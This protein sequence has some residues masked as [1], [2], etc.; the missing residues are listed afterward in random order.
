MTRNPD[1]TGPGLQRR[2]VLAATAAATVS[3]IAGLGT[4]AAGSGGRSF[5]LE[6]GGECQEVTALSTGETA[7]AF[8]DYR[9]GS[10]HTSTGIER[11]DVSNLFLFE[12]P[13]GTSL[14]VVHD[15]RPEGEDEPDGGAASFDIAG[16][17]A[18]GWVVIDDAGDFESA[19]DTSPD[20][21]WNRFN[22]DGGMWRGGLDGEFEVTVDPSFNEAAE[23]DLLTPGTIDEW[24]FL[25]GDADD[26]ERISLALDE[27][28]TVRP[29]TCPVAFEVDVKPDTEENPVNPDER[30]VVPVAVLATDGF[31][32]VDRMDVGTLRFGAPDTVAAGGGASPA[33]GGHAEDVDDDGNEDLLVHFPVEDTGLADGDTEARLVGATRD[34]TT[35][36]GT[37]DVRIVGGGNGKRKG[38]RRRNEKGSGDGKGR[39]ESNEKRG[40]KRNGTRKSEDDNDGNGD[41]TDEGDE[42]AKGKD[43]SDGK[44]KGNEKGT[45]NE[46]AKGKGK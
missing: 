20:W 19:T 27:P 4:A 39:A 9:S 31:D 23:R 32:P 26:P 43:A 35:L 17:T 10:A 11:E 40:A 45:S 34:G 3:A 5:V 42:T 7:E 44:G 41:G 33:H 46:R 14:G 28:V 1:T 22:T 15:H 30:G 24:Q 29:G 25:S 38:K 12:G 13:N 21:R 2:T 8:Y 16:L 6:Q 18:G 37:D 36:S